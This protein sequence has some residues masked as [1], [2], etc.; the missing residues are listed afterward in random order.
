MAL[1]PEAQK[2]F[3]DLVLP[4]VVEQLGKSSW[5]SVESYISAAWVLAPILGLVLDLEIGPWQL[6]LVAVSALVTVAFFF[7]RHSAKDQL[8]AFARDG[9]AQ[10]EAWADL[11]VVDG[12]PIEVRSIRFA[13]G[14]DALA[15]KAAD[16]P[17]SEVV[18]AE[19]AA[20]QG[21]AA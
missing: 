18:K 1:S 8:A 5:K 14:V 2:Q 3:L 19:G 4:K 16:Y 13:D 20:A 17:L 12:Y 15:F 7:R 9:I 6:G 10:D 11:P 21:A